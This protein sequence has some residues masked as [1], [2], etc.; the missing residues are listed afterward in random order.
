MAV[1]VT[2]NRSTLEVTWPALAV[3][4]KKNAIRNQWQFNQESIVKLSVQVFMCLQFL[5]QLINRLRAR[6]YSVG[7]NSYLNLYKAIQQWCSRMVEL[8]I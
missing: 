8:K 7:G 5:L 3:A 6:A 4:N 1:K 2:Y